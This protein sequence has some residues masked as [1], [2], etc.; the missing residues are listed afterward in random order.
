MVEG[1]R[2]EIVRTR[3]GSGGSNP[4]RTVRQQDVDPF[5]EMDC[6]GLLERFNKN[7]VWRSKTVLYVV[8]YGICKQFIQMESE[9]IFW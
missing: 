7:D 9:F 1:S 2:L 8:E 3:K 4:S 5:G 6:D